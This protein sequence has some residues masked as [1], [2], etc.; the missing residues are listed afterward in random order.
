[1]LVL[2]HGGTTVGLAFWESREIAEHNR[3]VRTQFLE[4]LST[5]ADLEVEERLGLEVAYAQLPQ[6]LSS[7]RG[8]R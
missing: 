3:F 2:S 4:R 7:S 8:A 6:S 5:I 1:M